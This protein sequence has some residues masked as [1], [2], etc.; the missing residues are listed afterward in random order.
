MY[1]ILIKNKLSL[2]GIMY[3]FGNKDLQR[4][5][6]LTVLTKLLHLKLDLHK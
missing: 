4:L 5:L 6:K 2:V 3:S 1:L